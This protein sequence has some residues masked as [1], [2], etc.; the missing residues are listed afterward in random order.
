MNTLYFGDNLT[1]MREHIKSNS[2]NLIYLD[3]PFNSN[4]TYNLLYKNATGIEVPEQA[5]AFSDTWELTESNDKMLRQLKVSYR[6]Q[7]ISED[8]LM[9]WKLWI[10]ALQ[11]TQPKVLAYLFYM[12]YRLL[13][14]RLLLKPK[15]SI[16]LHCDSTCSHYIK[17]M[18]DSIFGHKNFIN[19]IVWQRAAGR[20]KGSQHESKSWG[21]DTD[22][23]FY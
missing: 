5:E 23:I 20:A 8:Y 2:V 15:G 1:V 4:R 21:R 14:M 13:E 22:S 12:A 10:D 6:D 18:M 7:G 3:P 17:V 11:N 9:F 19:E 16:Y